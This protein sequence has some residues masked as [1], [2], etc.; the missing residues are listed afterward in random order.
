MGADIYV[1]DSQGELT[2]ANAVEQLRANG[3]GDLARV[4]N[5]VY[6]DR[7]GLSRTP[8]MPERNPAEEM[9]VDWTLFDPSFFTPTAYMRTARSC[10]FTCAFCNYPAIAGK[11][12]T[13]SVQAVERE[14]RTLH[15]A[16]CRHVIFIDDTFNVPLPRFKEICR[17]MIR[18]KFDFKWVSFFRCSNSDDEAFD[19]MAESGCLGVLLGIESGDQSVLDVMNKAVKI[20][21]YYN[22]VRKLKERGILTYTLF[23]F[24]HPGETPETAQ[25]TINFVRETGPDFYLAQL[26][27]HDTKVP[28]HRKS[29]ELGIHGA[30][31]SWKHRTMDW[32]EASQWVET[33]Y[34]SIDNSTILP[35]YGI[36]MW[37]LPYLLGKGISEGQFK[38]FTRIAHEMLV[39]SLPDVPVDFE[40]E[41][42]RLRTIFQAQPH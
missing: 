23:F 26:Y 32:R 4:P 35:L 21:K 20:E 27:Y 2:L 18:N 15:E 1:F 8:R 6:R 28:I 39:K 22:G 16:G 13:M 9:G 3:S 33:M 14:L 25:N 30:G 37:T 38:K 41:E 19:L 36:G 34:R 42:A 40:A 29:E 24:G 7:S 17:M 10:P 31:Y 5:L 12:E 11:H